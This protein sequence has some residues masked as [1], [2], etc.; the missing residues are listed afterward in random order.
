MR[1][2]FDKRFDIF[3]PSREI[4]DGLP[5]EGLEKITTVQG[6]LTVLNSAVGQAQN[7]G[8][9]EQRLVY[10]FSTH[11]AVDIQPEDIVVGNG[12]RVRVDA[13]RITSTGRR[14]ESLCEA[15]GEQGNI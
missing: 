6:R 13:V 11:S 1:G 2:I 9:Q 5:V 3:R 10:R 7:V 12:Q 15:I 8:T 14:K 4:V